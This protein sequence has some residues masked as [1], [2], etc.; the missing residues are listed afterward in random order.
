MENKKEVEKR[1]RERK[2]SPSA[3]LSLSLI[4][5][6]G[7]LILYVK[8]F[9]GFV[10]RAI[11]YRDCDKGTHAP[12]TRS[13]NH[14]RFFATWIRVAL[15]S[16]SCSKEV[17]MDHFDSSNQQILTKPPTQQPSAPSPPSSGDEFFSYSDLECSNKQK[18]QL[19]LGKLNWLAEMGLFGDQPDKE[20]LPAAEFPEL[21]VSHP[22]HVHLT[23]NP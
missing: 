12:D 8:F 14:Q 16:T 10:I 20:A 22:A 9:L 11:L 13:A 19:D 23:I 5:C 6:E 3:K 7:D 4:R 18:E 21:S 2:K 15:S 17:E 1:M